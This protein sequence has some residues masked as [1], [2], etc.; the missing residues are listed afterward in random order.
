M[1]SF[2]GRVLWATATVFTLVSS[3]YFSFRLKFIQFNL[4]EMFRNLFYKDKNKNGLS[5]FQVLMMTL[6]GRI[7]IGSIA[8]VALAIYIGGIGSIFWLWMIAIL[9]SVLAY[10]ET[11]LGML[12]K[13][14]DYGEVYKGGPS[15][16]LTYGLGKKSLGIIYA[17]L[18]II[19]YIGGFLGI[20]SNTIT[21]AVQE[22]IPISPQIIGILIVLIIAFI[23][24][25]GVKKI[26]STTEKLVPIM[27]LLYLG[28]A[29][30]I[31]LLH[32]HELP[33]LFQSIIKGAFNFQSFL[34]GFLT[35]FIVGI[36]RGIF[37][38]EAG[39]GTGSIAASTSS[40]DNPS[41]QGYLQ[42]LGIYITSLLICS[43][44]AVIILTSNYEVLQLSD[45]NGIEITQY[46]FQFHLGN[47]GNAFIFTSIFLFAFSTI[48][49]GYYYGESSL[50]YFF[51]ETKPI[52]L[53]LLKLL[54]L[55]VLFLGCIMSS[56]MLWKLVD[57]LVAF[58]VIINVYGLFGLREEVVKELQM[59]Q[60]R[61]RD[62]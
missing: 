11:V 47:V 10:A 13:K 57:T 50:K 61:K 34:G 4:K 43:A 27:T 52:Y 9:S 20:Q 6:A 8:G 51:K 28:V 16:Y 31:T 54:T 14:R 39:L 53:I 24:F 58:L 45:V 56:T 42:I 37:S 26:A 41:A 3:I 12:Y 29:F 46:A 2:L 21:R 33:F 18:I 36:Q 38:N 15:Y 17:I 60:K 1:L 22:I 59:Y 25:G 44:T 49:T 30:S 23:I 48:L 62:S 7:G 5:P 40:S 55:V 35:S 32:L 19:C